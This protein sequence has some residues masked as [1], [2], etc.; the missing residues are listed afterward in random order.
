MASATKPSKT[1]KILGTVSA[2]SA[3]I[4]VKKLLEISW[5]AATGHPPPSNPEHPDVEWHEALMFA[6]ASGAAVGL[7]RMLTA[8]KA[9]EYYRKST[10]HLPAGLEEVS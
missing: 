6:L 2:I 10:G 9:A 5:K 8:R 7:A 4:A 1:W 3:G